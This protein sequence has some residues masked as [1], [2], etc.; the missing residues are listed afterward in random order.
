MNAP[1]DDATYEESLAKITI[2]PPEPLQGRIEIRDYDPR[3]A[4]LFA[5]EA[6]R[7]RR[8]LGERVVRLEHVGSTSV[9]DLPAKPIIDIVL[10]V[11]DSSEEPAYV[12]DL[13]AGGYLLRIR[14]PRWFEHR[15]FKGPDT[16]INLHVFSA[17][18]G[19]TGR[20]TLFRD[21]LRGNDADR[22]RYAGVKRQLAGLDWKYVQQYADA[23]AD[24]IREI[25]TRAEAARNGPGE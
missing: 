17:G 11:L 25:M 24:V 23:K 9:P 4:T 15:M 7:I 5:R 3:S 22:R 20:M 6:D 2:G 14:E 16:N 21:W 12:P 18:C 13:E 8:L 19:E 10:E 1:E